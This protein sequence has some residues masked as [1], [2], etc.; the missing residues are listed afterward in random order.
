[1]SL[2]PLVLLDWRRRVAEL[3]AEVRAAAD[4]QAGWDRWRAGRDE[5]FAGHPASP[6]P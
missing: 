6:L 2:D 4:P 1:M 5:L 3:Y